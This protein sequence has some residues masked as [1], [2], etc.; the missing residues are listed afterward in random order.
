MTIGI[1]NLL[2]RLLGGA[3]IQVLSTSTTMQYWTA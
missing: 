2:A 3:A 1:R